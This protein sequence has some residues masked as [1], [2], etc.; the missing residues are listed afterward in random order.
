MALRNASAPVTADTVS[1]GRATIEHTGKRLDASHNIRT[2]RRQ[3][4][5]A[6]L[7]ARGPRP[8]LEA[9]L[10]VAAGADLDEVLEDF[11]RLT[12][13]LYQLMGAD[14]LPIDQLAILKGGR[15]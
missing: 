15:S 13:E 4:L 5:A 14:V 12:P 10:A 2:P 7:H 9:L 8:V 3:R 6:H 1:R 11:A